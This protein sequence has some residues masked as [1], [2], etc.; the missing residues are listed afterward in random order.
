MGIA[1][2]TAFT[3]SRLLEYF[4]ERELEMQIG[5]A[6]EDWPI[7]LLKELIDNGLDAC[8]AAGL[9]PK[10][11]IEVDTDHFRVE[12]DGPGMPPEVI[13]KVLDFSTRTST[14]SRYVSPTRGQLGNALKC[15]V[16]APSV[17]FPGTGQ[18]TIDAQD[19][20][21]RISITT[22]PIAQ[23][24]KVSYRREDVVKTG[25]SVRVDWPG[26]TI[27]SSTTTRASL[28]TTPMASPRPTPCSTPTPASASTAGSCWSRWAWTGGT[29]AGPRVPTGTTRFS[30]AT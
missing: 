4:T 16:A 13:E 14:N 11:D 9:P 20:R 1:E 17:M 8:E 5:H 24:P 3:T 2:R 7:A 6:C 22:D 18:V 23:E 19:V 10:V 27:A 25:T 28:F 26:L 30:Y 21:H 12:D 29:A 15:V